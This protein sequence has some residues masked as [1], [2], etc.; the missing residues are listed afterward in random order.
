MEISRS[1]VGRR[2]V[3]AKRKAAAKKKSTAA[4]AKAKV[5]SMR[6]QL[7][8]KAKTKTTPKSTAGGRNK[9][10]SRT[11]Q[12]AGRVAKKKPTAKSKSRPMPKLP[13]NMAGL[14]R[15]PLSALPGN[16]LKGSAVAFPGSFALR[17]MGKAAIQ[18]ALKTKAG[19]KFLTSVTDMFKRKPST[20]GRRK[21]TKKEKE[22]TKN[23]EQGYA[24]F[25]KNAREASR[26]NARR[27]GG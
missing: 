14:A 15:P 19:K 12:G 13:D 22:A 1:G 24:D 8:V 17:G 26:K 27:R 9:T 4:K 23:T 20:P 18:Q 10:A 16:I 11:P 5:E 21:A 6:K 3:N 25:K 7:G 2:A